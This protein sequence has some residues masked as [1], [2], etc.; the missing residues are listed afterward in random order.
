MQV[1]PGLTSQ[2]AVAAA[3]AAVASAQA[4]LSL[5]QAPSP[6]SQ[7]APALNPATLNPATLNSAT[8]NSAQDLELPYPL[9]IDGSI[10]VSASAPSSTSPTGQLPG[11]NNT[12]PAPTSSAANL[13]IT[14]QQ[15][16]PIIVALPPSSSPR[17]AEELSRL[18]AQLSS[19]R[20]DTPGVSSPPAPAPGTSGHSFPGPFEMQM[21]GVA[22]SQVGQQQAGG[23]APVLVAVP[24]QRFGAGTAAANM[25]S[26]A[27]GLSMYNTLMAEQ[28]A[29]E[30]PP[31]DVPRNRR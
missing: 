30:L 3:Q 31:E 20:P 10:P 17:T 15:P 1:P 2:A 13:G 23:A 19:A 18:V 6:A 5:S 22:A 12:V 16:Q 9:T 4:Q 14:A 11:P 27:A 7:Q 25:G 21:E 26:T 28:H 8:L 24:S 29:A